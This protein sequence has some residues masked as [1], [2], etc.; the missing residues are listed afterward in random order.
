MTLTATHTSTDVCSILDELKLKTLK[1]CYT[2]LLLDPNFSGLCGSEQL[3][4][5]LNSYKDKRDENRYRK[6]SKLSRMSDLPLFDFS[7]DVQLRN[8]LNAVLENIVLDDRRQRRN[9]LC[10]GNTGAGKTTFA[11]QV[12]DALMQSGFKAMFS[13]Y[14]LAIYELKGKLGT[15]DYVSRLDH[16]TKVRAC[17][18]DDAF[19]HKALEGESGI[20]KDLLDRCESNGCSLILTTQ[21]PVEKWAGH[22]G[23]GPAADACLDR[24]TNG[25]ILINFAGKSLRRK[26]AL[27]IE[28]SNGEHNDGI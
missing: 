28:V 18:L 3:Y 22:L 24:L 27:A 2:E 19:I 20:F 1:S 6:L 4:L 8:K 23:A 12:L 14:S 10:I 15:E 13:D 25:P 16:Y 21:L 17:L 5:L 11:A 9:V 26:Q 7:G